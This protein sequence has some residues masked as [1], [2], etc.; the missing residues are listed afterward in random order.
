M[1]TDGNVM[2]AAGNNGQLVLSKNR[3]V[4][5]ENIYVYEDDTTDQGWQTVAVSA[6]GQKMM[7]TSYSLR[8]HISSNGGTTWTD[9][10]PTGDRDETWVPGA[11]SGDGQTM[12]A[13]INN[14]RLYLSTNGGTSWQETRPGGDT[15]KPWQR[16]TMSYDGNVI[17]VGAY[18]NRLYL[19]TNRGV[20]WAETQPVGDNDANWISLGMSNNGQTMV[21]G[22]DAGRI[23][24]TKNGGT[25]WTEVQPL[26][27]TDNDWRVAS[28]TGDGSKIFIGEAPNTSSNGRLFLSTDG[29]TTFNE[30][31]PAGDADENWYLGAISRSGH[32]LLA[33]DNGGRLYGGGYP[34]PAV[35]SHTQ[36]ASQAQSCGDEKPSSAPE[37]FQIDVKG[38]TATMY[39]SPIGNTND[40][41]VSFSTDPGAEKYSATV[42]LAREGVQNYSVFMLQPNTNYYF[43][44]RGQHGCMPGEWSNVLSAKTGSTKSSVLQKYFLFN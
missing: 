21:A 19:S 26:G 44:V 42:N 32:T 30:T 13:G 23:Y 8:V 18:G 41:F 3:G 17:L 38:D 20:S 43:K 4:S 16:A 9:A 37:L 36:G 34:L 7:V 1:N 11:M 14:G 25:T 29:G 22:L 10:R 39:F 33:G 6:D 27:D 35:E 15:D 5:W 40:Y 12:L 2:L 31:R 24:L 28:V